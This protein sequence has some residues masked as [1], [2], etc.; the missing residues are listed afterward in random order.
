MF[1]SMFWMLYAWMCLRVGFVMCRICMCGFFNLWMNV[2]MGFCNVWMRVCVG[3]LICGCVYV[4]VL[5]CLNMCMCVF[6]NVWTCVSLGFV[7]CG[8]VYV[9]DL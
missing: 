8:Y 5:L 7:V 6:L 1:V 3:F 4:W 9:C 2:G